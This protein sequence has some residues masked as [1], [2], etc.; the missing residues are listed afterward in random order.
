M[1]NMQWGAREEELIYPVGE[2]ILAEG[3]E[4]PKLADC[5]AQSPNQH[6]MQI[7]KGF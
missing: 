7:T 3:L 1:G 5:E 2:R 4:I 6:A